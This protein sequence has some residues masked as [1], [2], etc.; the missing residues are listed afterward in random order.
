MPIDFSI[1]D[2]GHF[3]ETMISGELSC[4]ELV[5]YEIAHT[6][7]ERLRSP[8]L[9]LLEVSPGSICRLDDG[10]LAAIFECRKE[11]AR[12]FR[13]HRC[14]LVISPEDVRAPELNRFFA[15]LTLLHSPEVVV[16]FGDA[17]TARALM[18]R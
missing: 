18:D 6:T 3:I 14:V 12:L 8:L 2:D 4:P 7:D 9:E 5:E 15:D 13:S 17:P 1:S 10:E 16:I 11:N